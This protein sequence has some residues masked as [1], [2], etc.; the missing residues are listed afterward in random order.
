MIEQEFIET[1]DK[2]LDSYSEGLVQFGNETKEDAL[3]QYATL[4]PDGFHT[5]GTAFYVALNP[6]N[7]EIGVVFLIDRQP[8]VALLMWIEVKEQFRRRGYARNILTL[9]ADEMIAKNHSMIVL[10]VFEINKGAK[11][12]YESC[13]YTIHSID[14]GAITMIKALNRQ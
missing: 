14:N 12:L 6:E 11:A 9:I 3:E 1:R 5:P 8:G 10:N 2:I 7:E 4:L 13:G